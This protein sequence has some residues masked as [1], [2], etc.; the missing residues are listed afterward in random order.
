MD[1]QDR[2]SDL[3]SAFLRE[4]SSVLPGTVW[5]ELH[6]GTSLDYPH[7]SPVLGTLSVGFEW[8]ELI[9]FVG[10]RG[11][12]THF[13]VDDSRAD[14]QTE[15]ITEAARTALVFVRDIVQ[16]RLSIRW[17]L[18]VSG[19]HSARR[20]ATAAGRVWRWLTP[21]VRDAVWSGRT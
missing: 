12:H 10:P 1:E 4:S 21:W 20:G 18:L 2:L 16:D 7:K 17:G 15:Q 5:R 19:A 6:D 3:R 14:N 11:H 9:I 13:A 8:D